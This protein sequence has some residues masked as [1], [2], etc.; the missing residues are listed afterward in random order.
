MLLSFEFPRHSLLLLNYRKRGGGRA[1]WCL[2]AGKSDDGKEGGRI[3]T[4]HLMI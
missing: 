4:G 2:L 3:S 1:E